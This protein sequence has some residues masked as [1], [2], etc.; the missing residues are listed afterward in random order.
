VHM[1]HQ[2]LATRHCGFRLSGVLF[3]PSRFR[4]KLDSSN[5]VPVH[6]TLC[7]SMGQAIRYYPKP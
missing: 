5:V 4:M 7:N 6:K 2:L 1:D 3:S